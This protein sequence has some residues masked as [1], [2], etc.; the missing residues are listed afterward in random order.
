MAFDD[1]DFASI[2]KSKGYTGAKF[3]ESK[4]IQ[5][6]S[7]ASGDTYIVFD[8]QSIVFC[9]KKPTMEDFVAHLRELPGLN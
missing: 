7:G 8:P 1:P 5:R 3:P 4:S 9:R 2:V 6:A